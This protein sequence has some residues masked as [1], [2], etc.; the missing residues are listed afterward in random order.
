M[1]LSSIVIAKNE[2]SNIRRCIE[3]Q[4]NCIDEI[5]VLVDNDTTDNTFEISKSY[6][7]VKAHLVKWQG[8]SSTKNIA[9]SMTSNNWILWIDADEEI[10]PELSEELKTFKNTNPDYLAYSIPRKAYFLGKWIKHSGWYPGR[11]TRLFNKSNGKFN[12]NAVHEQLEFAGKTGKLSGNLNHY[13]DPSIHHYFEKYNH[14]TSLAAGELSNKGK[15]FSLSDIILR[16]LS[17]F[18]KMYLLKAGFLDG[19]QG[20]ILAAFSSSYVFTKYCKLWELEK[21]NK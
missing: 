8:Y 10:T 6:K 3:S 13:T 19:I 15:K 17:I 20:F 11:V 5:I 9:I 1:K 14:Y 4:Q 16:P 2:E 12:A 18:I 21:N 7:N